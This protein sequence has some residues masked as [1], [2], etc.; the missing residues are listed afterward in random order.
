M[1][2]RE[3]YNFDP[4]DPRFI[5]ELLRGPLDGGSPRFGGNL[6]YDR[7]ANIRNAGIV[8]KALAVLGPTPPVGMT[9]R[10]S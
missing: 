7:L 3:S 1:L 9:T 10:V 4:G 8:L 2:G 6:W 5:T